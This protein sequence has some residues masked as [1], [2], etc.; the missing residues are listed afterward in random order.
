MRPPPVCPGAAG[1]LSLHGRD[2]QLQRAL[3]L[4]GVELHQIG[5][6]TFD[7]L[8]GLSLWQEI[9]ARRVGAGVAQT[10]DGSFVLLVLIE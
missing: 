2:D 9:G 6:G 7:A 1:H 5:A 4:T 8:L 3:G 10:G